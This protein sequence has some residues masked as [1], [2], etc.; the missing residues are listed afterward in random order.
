VS[1]G[2]ILVELPYGAKKPRK[3]HRVVVNL[4][5]DCS[6]SLRVVSV[7][8]ETAALYRITVASP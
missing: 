2:E 5:K 3:G 7:K 4:G 6:V 1:I 8:R